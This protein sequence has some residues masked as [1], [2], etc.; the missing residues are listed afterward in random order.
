MKHIW[1]YISA[2]LQAQD[3]ISPKEKA[4]SLSYSGLVTV[5]PISDESQTTEAWQSVALS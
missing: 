5:E 3:P 1:L 2:A 4:V